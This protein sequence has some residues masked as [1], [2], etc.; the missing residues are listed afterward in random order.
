[1]YRDPDLNP[2]RQPARIGTRMLRRVQAVVSPLRW[3]RRDILRLLGRQLTE[4]KPRVFFFPP[5]AP[6]TPAR[7]AARCRR[8]GPR[9]DPRSRMLY[10]GGMLFVNGD[11]LEG[12]DRGTA[13]LLRRLANRREL[14][15]CDPGS[16]ARALL[17]RWYRCGYILP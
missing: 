10:A 15:P 13:A 9:L 4:P 8:R 1:M 6:L 16:E 5:R 2:Q 11:S 3:S 7:F 14:P 17:Y 12:L